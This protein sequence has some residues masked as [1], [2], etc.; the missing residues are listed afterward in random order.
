[1]TNIM[2]MSKKIY[3]PQ[4][5]MISIYY[6][7]NDRKLYNSTKLR[8]KECARHEIHRNRPSH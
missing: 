3:I 6:Y 4:L 1:M 7:Y 8:R 2:K 5:D